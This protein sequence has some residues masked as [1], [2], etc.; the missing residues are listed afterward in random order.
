LSLTEAAANEVAGQGVRVTAV[1]PGPVDTMFHT[2]MG[3]EASL[4]RLLL[5]ALTPERVARS[6]YSGF[7]MK[8]RIVVPGL[9]NKVMFVA[10]KYIPHVV[11]VP[12]VAELLKR[13]ERSVN[14]R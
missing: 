7:M 1:A 9:F 13:S 14:A 2:N 10:L 4:Y 6:A 5:P 8:R 11:T 3:A 12:F